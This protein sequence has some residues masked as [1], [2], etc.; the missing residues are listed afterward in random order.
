MVFLHQGLY[1]GDF[2]NRG[3]N[4]F[5]VIGLDSLVSPLP[6]HSGKRTT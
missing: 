4:V 3:I 1:I 5:L 2:S 6:I